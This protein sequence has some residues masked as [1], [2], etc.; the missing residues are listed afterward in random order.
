MHACCESV[1]MWFLLLCLCLHMHYSICPHQ[2]RNYTTE[3][4]SVAASPISFTLGVP[5][6]PTSS[7]TLYVPVSPTSSPTLYV[8]VSPTSSPT[9]YVPVSPTSSPTLYIGVIRN[10]FLLLKQIMMWQLWSKNK[11]CDLL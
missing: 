10:K 5:V 11:K 1:D 4:S 8:P 6:S 2:I 7:P 3:P 9:L